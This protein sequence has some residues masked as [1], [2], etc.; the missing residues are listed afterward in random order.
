VKSRKKNT[1]WELNGGKV[2]VLSG[3]DWVRRTEDMW[4]EKV[5]L[6]TFLTFALDTD[7]CSNS[8]S[9]ASLMRLLSTTNLDASGNLFL[10][11]T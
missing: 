11:G 6:H 9:T 2:E 7:E 3:S 5:Q 8:L 1:D 4:R 10:N